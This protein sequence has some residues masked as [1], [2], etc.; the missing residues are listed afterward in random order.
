MPFCIDRLSCDYYRSF[1]RFSCYCLVL[2]LTILSLFSPTINTS[3]IHPFLD[4][5]AA[6]A[7][8]SLRGNTSSSASGSGEIALEGGLVAAILQTAKGKKLMSRR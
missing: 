6:Q 1:P 4:A 2:S 7:I 3:I 5:T 8:N